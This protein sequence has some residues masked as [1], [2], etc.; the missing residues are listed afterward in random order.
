MLVVDYFILI[1]AVALI[2]FSALQQS[3]DDA[4]DAFRGTSSDLFKN[5]KFSGAELFLNRGMAILSL[6]IIVLVVVSNNI[7]RLSIGV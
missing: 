4:V 6:T 2:V 3:N 7:D 1:I 5:R